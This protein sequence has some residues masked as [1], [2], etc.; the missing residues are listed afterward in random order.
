MESF[1]EIGGKINNIFKRN[2]II[3]KENK[4]D[5]IKQ[6]NFKDTYSTIYEYDNKDQSKANFIAPLYLDLDIDDLENDFDKLKVDLF[7]L[8]RKLKTMFYLSEDNMEIYFSGSKGFHIIIPHEIFGFE[9]SR[10]LNIKYKTLSLEL[11]SYTITKSIDTRIYDNKRLFREPNTINSKTGLYKVQVSLDDLRNFNYNDIIEYASTTHEIKQA[12]IENNRKA[13][14]VFDS[15]IEN[16]KQK[17]QRSINNRVAGAM[18]ANKEI[19]PCVKYILANGAVTGGRNN[20]AIALASALFQREMD[21][22]KVMDIMI[23][24]NETKLDEPLPQREI[25]ATVK[26]AYN[27]VKNGRRYG[28]GAFI[29]LGICIKGCPVRK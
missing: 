11:N 16:N 17:Q 2:I 20:T 23:E 18:M 1:V 26:S 28:C 22:D 4:Q 5:T 7:L 10:D 27:N 9:Y 3:K 14:E 29:D 24:W 21:E 12:R 6:Y 19:L 15:F 13:R 25:T 8:I